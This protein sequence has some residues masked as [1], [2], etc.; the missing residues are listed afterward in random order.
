M[1][2][3][4]MEP[5]VFVPVFFCIELL[6]SWDVESELEEKNPNNFFI[7]LEAPLSKHHEPNHS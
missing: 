5:K 6:E 7:T 3:R 2:F 1:T 4:I